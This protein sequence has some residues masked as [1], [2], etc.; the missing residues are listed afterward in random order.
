MNKTTTQAIKRMTAI[1]LVG[2][3][4]GLTAAFATIGFVELVHYLNDVLYV[5]ASS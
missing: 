4:A 5:S 1:S 3:V 2:L